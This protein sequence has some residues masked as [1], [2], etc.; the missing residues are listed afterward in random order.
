M[1]FADGMAE[2]FAMMYVGDEDDDVPMKPLP[3]PPKAEV[4]GG[5]VL[6]LSC[7]ALLV[8]FTCICLEVVKNIYDVS[9]FHKDSN[10][11]LTIMVPLTGVVGVIASRKMRKWV[12]VL[13][14]Y[15]II[16]T[17]ITC[18]ILLV[19]NAFIVY[20]LSHDGAEFQSSGTN[21]DGMSAP[22][23]YEQFRT[24]FKIY[25]AVA[26]AACTCQSIAVFTITWLGYYAFKIFQVACSICR[27][28]LGTI[29]ND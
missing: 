3:E 24:K 18:F 10:V 26:I 12:Y 29:E 14:L 6:H 22:D 5:R 2:M 28:N 23:Y 4:N 13:L 19:R 16:P 20:Y 27:D 9:F 8:G 7:G 11:Y 15:T 1:D 25:H 21:V 17:A